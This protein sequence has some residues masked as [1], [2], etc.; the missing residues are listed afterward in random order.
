[1]SQ[2]ERTLVL[3]K[4]DGVERGLTGEI[5]A[6]IER[7]GYQITE[8]LMLNATPQMLA[9]HYEEHQG[10]DFFEPLV[11]FMASG[12]IVAAIFEGDRVIE[13]IRQ[14]AGISDPTLADAGT[15]RGDFGR[16]WGESVQ[17]NLIHASDST[18]SAEREIDLWFG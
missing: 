7:K 4:P 14:L 18:L 6:R 16:D 1:M 13:G 17:K 9:E 12:P 5:L 11:N 2:P 3:V 8:L 10:K 15:I